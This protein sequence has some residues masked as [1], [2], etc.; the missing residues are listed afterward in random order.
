MNAAV[1]MGRRP[2]GKWG[3][4]FTAGAPRR[5][6]ERLDPAGSPGVLPFNAQEYAVWIAVI[7]FAFERGGVTAA[8]AVL[9]V[10]LVPAALVAP[11]T[12]AIGDRMRRD[13]ALGIGY[14]TQAIANAVLAIALWK[15]PAFVAYGAAVV[16]NC[17]ITL[18]RPVQS[19]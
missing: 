12:A 6:R 14:A 18:T 4:R 7:V 16:S 9:V 13:R 15:A 8:G 2:D 10:Q 17:A 3:G 11:F 19:I 1:K 5:R